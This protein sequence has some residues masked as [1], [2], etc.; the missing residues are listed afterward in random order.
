MRTSFIHEHQYVQD[1]DTAL[2]T[3]ASSGHEAVVNTLLIHGADIIARGQVG[4]DIWLYTSSC[5]FVSAIAKAASD[6]LA[7][8]SSSLP[9]DFYS[10]LS[11]M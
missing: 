11:L 8:Q 7:S 4:C 9:G 3:A 2:I 10:R 6:V 5:L 1:N